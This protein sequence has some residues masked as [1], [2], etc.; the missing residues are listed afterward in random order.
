MFSGHFERIIRRHSFVDMKCS[1]VCA[2]IY[3][4]LSFPYFFKAAFLLLRNHLPRKICGWIFVVLLS[5]MD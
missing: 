2:W 1:L 5:M 4:I 3:Y